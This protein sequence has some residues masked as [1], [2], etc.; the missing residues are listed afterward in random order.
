MIINDDFNNDFYKFNEASK[1]P[2]ISGFNTMN[3]RSI[4]FS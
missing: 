1:P 3:I 4:D 2:L